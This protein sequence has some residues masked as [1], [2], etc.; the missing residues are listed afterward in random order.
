MKN[1]LK[2][3][4]N[5]SSQGDK[6]KKRRVG[7]HW[8][9]IGSKPPNFLWWGNCHWL[10]RK[11]GNTEKWF[12]YHLFIA[13]QPLLPFPAF[14]VFLIVSFPNSGSHGAFLNHS[15]YSFKDMFCPFF[16]SDQSGKDVTTQAFSGKPFGPK[17]YNHFKA[18]P[19]MT[20]LWLEGN[21]LGV[22]RKP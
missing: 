1:E 22:E 9:F 14:C 10:W 15:K 2:C 12:W 7:H 16:N 3:L 20:S 8:N 11:H 19:W 21:G 4:A 17:P 13:P 6:M 5:D 18:S